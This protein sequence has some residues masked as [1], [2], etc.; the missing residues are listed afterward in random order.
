MNTLEAFSIEN[1]FGKVDECAKFTI[2]DIASYFLFSN[3]ATIDQKYTLSFWVKG[4]ATGSLSVAGDS[5]AVTVEWQKRVVTFTASNESIAMLFETVGTY[6][7]YHPKLEVGNKATDWS[8]AP[9]DTD[10]SIEDAKSEANDAV[11][12]A[13]DRI[14][15]AESLI[16][17]LADCISMLVTDENG[18]SLMTQTEDGWTFCMQEI[19]SAV[20]GIRDALDELQTLTGSTSDTV[21]LLDQAVKNNSATLEYVNISTYNDQP[22]I[23][24]GENDTSFKLLITNTDI[25]FWNGSD[26]STRV[27]TDGIETD[28]IKVGGEI[29]QGGYVMM[30]TSD[31]GWG[32]LWKGVSS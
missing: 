6:Y 22:C 19:N 8:P 5:C 26:F 9:E 16:E 17:Q 4:D 31:G 18:E 13:N 30:N 1:P 24:L 15:Q 32:I 23:E 14:A 28:N 20:S 12:K 27:N 7:I 2:D 21:G 3:I 10:E 29:I 11:G 25:R